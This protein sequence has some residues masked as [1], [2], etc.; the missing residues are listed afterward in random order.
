MKRNIKFIL[1]N[2][3]RFEHDD[4][5][6]PMQKLDIFHEIKKMHLKKGEIKKEI[7]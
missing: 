7:Y 6:L 4:T 5:V 2:Q 3:R 1:T